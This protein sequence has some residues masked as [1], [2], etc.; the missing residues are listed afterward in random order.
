MWLCSLFVVRY[1]CCL[2]VRFLFFFFND[3]ATTEIY[4]LHIVGSVRCVQETDAEYMGC[5]QTCPTGIDIR[6]GLQ[7]ECVNCTQCIDA[8]DSVMDKINRPRGLI[9]YS[10]QSA[11]ETGKRKMF[12]PRVALYPILL[13]ILV[14][15]FTIVL[16]R[17]SPVDVFLTHS[18]GNP[19]MTMPSGEIANSLRLKIVNRTDLEESYKLSIVGTDKARIILTDNPLVIAAGQ[20]R[21]VPCILAADPSLL[22]KGS[23]FITLR[24]TDGKQRVKDVTFRL[25]GPGGSFGDLR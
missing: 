1:Q 3:T 8:C 5:V 7:M 14:T 4:T 12:R 15:I 6:E 11:I 23:F 21:E 2:L 17:K 25:L 22:P 20:S 10:S 13:A 9:R 19:Y 16:V 18:A 24:I